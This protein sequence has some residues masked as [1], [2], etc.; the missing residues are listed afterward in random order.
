MTPGKYG[1]LA[2]GKL[3]KTTW[4]RGTYAAREAAIRVQLAPQG[5]S[6]QE[7]IFLSQLIETNGVYKRVVSVEGRQCKHTVARSPLRITGD[8]LAALYTNNRSKAS[9]EA[10]RNLYLG[11]DPREGDVTLHIHQSGL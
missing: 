2:R 5:R 9:I 8:G 4:H 7:D 1:A 6:H 11:F 10:Q 3:L